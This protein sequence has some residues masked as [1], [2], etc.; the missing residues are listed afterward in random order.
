MKNTEWLKSLRSSDAV[1][2]GRPGQKP[3]S[4]PPVKYTFGLIESISTTGIIKLQKGEE[5]DS[6]GSRRDQMTFIRDYLIPVE[7]AYK[8]LKAAE[9]EAL[10]KL[11]VYKLKDK[12]EN[13]LSNMSSEQL[14][15]LHDFLD[16]L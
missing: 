4:E 1:A 5:F 12:I 13:R 3:D 15:R 2:F 10:R 14:S 16:A 7:E 11:S 8:T 9:T 6:D